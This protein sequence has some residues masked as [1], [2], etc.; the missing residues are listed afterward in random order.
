MR[1]FKRVFGLALIAAGVCLAQSAPAKAGCLGFSGTADGFDKVTAVTR[2]QAAVA[3][4]INQYKASKKL[5]S[6]TVTA[7]RAKPQPYW[8]DS[9]SENLFFKPDIVKSNSYTVCWTGV[10]SPYV[11]TSGAKVCW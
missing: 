4:A 2:A 9:V 1:S 8:R 7:M 6:V 10:V 5:G 3:D 11:C